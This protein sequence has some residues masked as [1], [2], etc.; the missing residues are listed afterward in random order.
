MDWSL[1]GQQQPTIPR[2]SNTEPIHA[3]MN[4]VGDPALMPTREMKDVAA[5]MNQLHDTVRAVVVR[6]IGPKMLQY[7]RLRSRL[8]RLGAQHR[9]AVAANS[10]AQRNTP[11]PGD[12]IIDLTGPPNVDLAETAVIDFAETAVV[13]V[14][15]SVADSNETVM[16]ST[17]TAVMDSTETEMATAAPGG[18]AAA[19][20]APESHGLASVPGEQIQHGT[21]VQ[22][23]GQEYPRKRRRQE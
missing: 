3:T 17:E 11:R 13:D 23:L 14:A 16:D 15:E 21:Q 12:T 7:R 5:Q 1:H 4:P 22:T 10:G 6:Y 2:R 18:T 8:M 20:A 19:T 9:A